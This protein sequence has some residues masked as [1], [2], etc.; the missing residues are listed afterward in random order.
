M[1]SLLD[2]TTAPTPKASAH[3]LQVQ[4]LVT[5]YGLT[6]PIAALI[7]SHAFGVRP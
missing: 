7:A 5:L 1:L 3:F 4:R 6:E 2:G